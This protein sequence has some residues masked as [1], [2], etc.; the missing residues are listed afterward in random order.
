MRDD[1]DLD[2]D[3]GPIHEVN[4]E[5][6]REPTYSMDTKGEETAEKRKKIIQVIKKRNFFSRTI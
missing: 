1:L 5:N 6:V 3:A 4:K 2:P